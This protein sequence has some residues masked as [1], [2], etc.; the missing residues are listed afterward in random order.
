MKLSLIGLLT[1]WPFL[2]VPFNLDKSSVEKL[3]PCPKSP[4]CVCTQDDNSRKKVDPICF[5]G[6]TEQAA[7]R[8]ERLISSYAYAKLVRQESN[9]YHYEFITKLGKF[10]DDVEFLID[11]KAKLIHFRSASRT[12]YSDLGKNK[13]R[14][15]KIKKDWIIKN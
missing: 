15:K 14:M 1:V 3:K 13:R 8:L 10:I 4:N 6:D 7:K 2:I 12:G 11:P 5:T 9:Y